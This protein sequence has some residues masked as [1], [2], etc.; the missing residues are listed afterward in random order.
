MRPKL[1]YKKEYPSFKK[2]SCH[3]QKNMPY[4]GESNFYLFLLTSQKKTLVFILFIYSF[5]FY[6]YFSSFYSFYNFSI[7]TATRKKMSNLMNLQTREYI[8]HSIRKSTPRTYPNVIL[9]HDSAPDLEIEP[10]PDPYSGLNNQYSPSSSSGSSPE[11]E[12]DHEP[13]SITETGN[14]EHNRLKTGQFDTSSIPIAI[15]TSQ[16]KAVNK[17]RVSNQRIRKELTTPYYSCPEGW[18]PLPEGYYNTSD[19]VIIPTTAEIVHKFDREDLEK[20]LDYYTTYPRLLYETATASGVDRFAKKVCWDFY[21]SKNKVYGELT[22]GKK[23]RD[24][25][26]HRLN[27]FKNKRTKKN[28]K[29]SSTSINS[30]IPSNLNATKEKSHRATID[31]SLA[32]IVELQNQLEKCKQSYVTVK[33]A[34]SQARK[35]NSEKSKDNTPI[36][37]KNINSFSNIP[38]LPTSTVSN[39]TQIEIASNPS[40]RM[41]IPTG[42]AQVTNNKDQSKAPSI[43]DSFISYSESLNNLQGEMKR[44]VYKMSERVGENYEMTNRMASDISKKSEENYKILRQEINDI[45]TKIDEKFDQIFLKFRGLEQIMLSK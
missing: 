23:L 22:S 18:G 20:Y 31:D 37:E 38:K 8:D 16:Q 41:M 15:T 34:K 36:P 45:N 21:K 33:T 35:S 29:A 12:S 24:S 27:R 17:P 13:N 4:D 10:E 25:F 3:L 6:F 7:F 39:E 2:K 40:G 30:P 11:P 44:L 28:P 43:E 42:P 9:Q 19:N 1:I 32:K 26:R 14:N 5:L